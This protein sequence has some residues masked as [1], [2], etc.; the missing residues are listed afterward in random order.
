MFTDADLVHDKETF[1]FFK[2]A[3]VRKNSV[4]LFITDKSSYDLMSK[5]YGAHKW[6]TI[7]E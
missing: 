6:M 7:L 4:A 3:K 2:L 5:T 1:K